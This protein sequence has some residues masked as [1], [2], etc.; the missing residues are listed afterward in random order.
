ML[1]IDG[2]LSE[3]ELLHLEIVEKIF[4]QRV[5]ILKSSSGN[6]KKLIGLSIR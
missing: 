2:Q 1:S 3:A 6:F 4:E 5:N